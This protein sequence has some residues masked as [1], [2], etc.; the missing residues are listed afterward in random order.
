M[1]KSY[2]VCWL[3]I[4]ATFLVI[5]AVWLFSMTDSFYKPLL[6]DLLRAVPDMR[7]VAGFYLIYPLAVLILA[8]EPATRAASP[9]R[10]FLL[11]AM[12]GLAAYGTYDMTN[13][14]TIKGWSPIVAIVDLLWGSLLTALCSLAGYYSLCRGSRCPPG[15]P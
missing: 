10:A 9:L 3:V 6:G 7:A 14:A 13:L 2:V 15:R 11:G 4:A 5:D 1:L 12:L 8:S